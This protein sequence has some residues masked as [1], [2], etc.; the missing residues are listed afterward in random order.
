MQEVT[1]TLKIVPAIAQ[2]I[3]LVG[4]KELVLPAC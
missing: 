3:G 4:L 1:G 2:M